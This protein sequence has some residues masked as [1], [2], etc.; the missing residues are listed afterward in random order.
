[1]YPFKLYRVSHKDGNDP[2]PS[3]AEFVRVL[4]KKGCVSHLSP[5]SIHINYIHHFSKT[6]SLFSAIEPQ[7]FSEKKNRY[8]I[9]IYANIDFD[10]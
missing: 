8:R 6:L 10:C 3:I 9:M 2:T 4:L 5:T 7:F 1:M